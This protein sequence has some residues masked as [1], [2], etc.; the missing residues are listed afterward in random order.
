MLEQKSDEMLEQKSD[1]MLEQKSDE[2]LEQKS[3]DNRDISVTISATSLET[4]YNSAASTN[5]L[6]Q[7]VPTMLNLLLE[8]HIN[9]LH[10]G[11]LD[12]NYG[13]D[14]SDTS[15]EVVD[16]DPDGPEEIPE[17][18]FNTCCVCFIVAVSLPLPCCGQHVCPGCLKLYCD[19]QPPFSTLPSPYVLPGSHTWLSSAIRN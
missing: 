15:Q 10:D 9:G 1:E 14:D 17:F 12:A 4:G 13:N 7:N 5:D 8:S 11:D 19:S 2:M 3:E 16:D 6:H 18:T